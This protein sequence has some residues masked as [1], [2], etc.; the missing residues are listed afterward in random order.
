MDPLTVSVND[1]LALHVALEGGG[2]NE[3]CWMLLQHMKKR[4]FSDRT[5]LLLSADAMTLEGLRQLLGHMTSV[6]DLR[7]VL[8]LGFKA[9]SPSE[10]HAVLIEAFQE[11]IREKLVLDDHAAVFFKVGL[12]ECR[13]QELISEA[14][15]I[16]WDLKT[17]KVNVENS[18]WVREIKHTL[19]EVECRATT[20]ERNIGLLHAHINAL[21]DALVQNQEYETKRRT[22]DRLL[23]LVSSALVLCGGLVIKDVVGAIF[24]IWDPAKLLGTD[25]HEFGQDGRL[26][27]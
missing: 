18:E 22:R 3:M 6:Y 1:K 27:G 24:D 23:S 5:T 8:S 4:A 10:M 19:Q 9:F 20:A 2:S 12:Q 13:R 14:E 25:E 21:R 26:P 16:E 7:L 15:L 11:V 17:T